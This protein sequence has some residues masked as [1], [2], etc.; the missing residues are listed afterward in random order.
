M[1]SLFATIPQNP[2]ASASS[3]VFPDIQ[4]EHFNQ[5]D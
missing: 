3:F 4:F 1:K 5:K 2:P